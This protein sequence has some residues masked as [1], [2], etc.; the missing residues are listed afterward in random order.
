[1]LPIL[2]SDTEIE[3]ERKADRQRERGERGKGRYS[4]YCTKVI[5]RE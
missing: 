4:K 1:M 5:E 3:R 2:S